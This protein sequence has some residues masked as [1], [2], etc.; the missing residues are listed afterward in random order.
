MLLRF[1]VGDLRRRRVHRGEPAGDGVLAQGEARGQNSARDHGRL[2]A[3]LRHD[4]GPDAAHARRSLRRRPELAVRAC[5]AGGSRS[6]SAACSPLAFVVVLRALRS[7]SPSSSRPRAAATRRRS[8]SSSARGRSG[9]TSRQ[10]FVL[11]TGFWLSLN[12][13]TAILPG[14][15]AGHARPVGYRH[16]H[17]AD[18]RLLGHGVRLRRRRGDQ[19]ADRPPAVPHGVGDHR[20]GGRHVLLLAAAV[21]QA[22]QPARR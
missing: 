20:R 21:D 1:I 18:R 7:T 13:V 6:S 4:L 10:V 22:E 2:P 14:G 9:A 11:M 19:P 15:P 17:H 12:T 5:G 16:Q 3:G 8:R